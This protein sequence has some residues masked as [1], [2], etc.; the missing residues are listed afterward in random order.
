MKHYVP[1]VVLVVLSVILAACTTVA[2]AP[3]PPAGTQ[4]E[5]ALP[6]DAATDQTLRYVFQRVS[7]PWFDPAQMSGYARFIL[8]IL[9]S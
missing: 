3:E 5:R 7:L 6:A 8:A 4:P 9:H 2:P 1:I